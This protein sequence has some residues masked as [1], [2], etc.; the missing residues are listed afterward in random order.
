M[1]LLVEVRSETMDALRGAD[2]L[3][4]LY[5]DRQLRYTV[6]FHVNVHLCQLVYRN[7]VVGKLNRI[8]LSIEKPYS[9][10]L[11]PQ[12]HCA[13]QLYANLLKCIEVVC[14]ST[15]FAAFFSLRLASGD[16]MCCTCVSLPFVACT[17]VVGG[18]WPAI[19][20]VRCIEVRLGEMRMFSL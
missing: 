16:R 17:F 14:N 1:W 10:S 7:L 4:P 11:T 9:L 3:M 12:V 5:T 13:F 19:S 15:T 8:L 6:Q 2:W 18:G 20:P